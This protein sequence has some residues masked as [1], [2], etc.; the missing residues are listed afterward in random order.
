M[1][2]DSPWN[3]EQIPQESN[4]LRQIP[5]FKRDTETAR[6]H[7]FPGPDHFA[8]RED[9]EEDSLSF[10]WE[11]YASIEK[12]YTLIALTIGS[13][14]KHIDYTGYVFYRYPVEFIIGLPKF[15]K[16]IHDPKFYGNPSK[17][18]QPNNKSH[19]LLYCGNFD[20]STRA[21]LSLYC[22]EETGS[23]LAFK[24]KTIRDDI[25]DLKTRAPDIPYHKDWVF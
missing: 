20:V 17:V 19:A 15:E 4:L 16:L 9:L 1:N 14:G 7:K 3:S 23:L 18:G 2:N 24:V 11:T 10:N 22:Q 13:N 8:L 25:E 21:L 12:S 5:A 6:P